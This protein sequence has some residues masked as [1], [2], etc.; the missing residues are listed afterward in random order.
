MI[1]FETKQPIFY[2]T[3]DDLSNYSKEKVW[4]GH[5]LNGYEE[6]AD[7]I[8]FN[9]PSPAG[10][11]P[12]SADRMEFEQRGGAFHWDGIKEWRGHYWGI[13]SESEK[14]ILLSECWEDNN[15]PHVASGVFIAIFPKERMKRTIQ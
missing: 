11:W 9:Y 15:P 13:K 1:N 8:T 7:A 5:E 14:H 10:L 12:H 4:T 6:S 3:Y 2:W